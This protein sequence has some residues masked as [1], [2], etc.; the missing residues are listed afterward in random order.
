MLGGA[1]LVGLRRRLPQSRLAL[2]YALL[3]VVYV[4]D[5]WRSPSCSVG[6][7]AHV[8]AQA[9]DRSRFCDY[10]L[11]DGENGIGAIKRLQSNTRTRS[12]R[13]DHWRHGRPIAS[14]RRGRAV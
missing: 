7:Q 3:I 10:R 6:V 1:I 9:L 2:W 13:P 11:R 8:S 12:G 4:A 14:R 5:R